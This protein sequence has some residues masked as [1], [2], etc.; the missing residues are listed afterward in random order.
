MANDGGKEMHSS[1]GQLQMISWYVGHQRFY[2]G[3]T[4]GSFASL[5]TAMSRSTPS[6]VAWRYV[7]AGKHLSCL[8]AVQPCDIDS[9]EINNTN[10]TPTDSRC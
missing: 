6:S 1:C 4:T 10:I 7:V 3:L 2:C 9:S 8:A 5:N